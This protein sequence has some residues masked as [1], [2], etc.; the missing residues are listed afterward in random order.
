[1]VVSALS[2][3]NV[4]ESVVLRLGVTG[5]EILIE[6]F[7][8]ALI[9]FVDALVQADGLFLQLLLLDAHELPLFAFLQ[10]LKNINSLLVR[11]LLDERYIH[12]RDDWRHRLVRLDHILLLWVLQ[13]VENAGLIIFGDRSAGSGIGPSRIGGGSEFIYVNWLLLKH[14]LGIIAIQS[15]NRTISHQ[16]LIARLHR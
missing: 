15:L 9:S 1:M 11:Q 7:T 13:L 14:L 10:D 5:F 4:Q 12:F 8:G 16:I 2:S 6:T 3:D